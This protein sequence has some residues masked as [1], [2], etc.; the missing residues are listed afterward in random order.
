M[1]MHN[2]LKVQSASIVDL[3]LDLLNKHLM[4]PICLPLHRTTFSR[5][6]AEH[7]Q[8]DRSGTLTNDEWIELWLQTTIKCQWLLISVDAQCTLNSS[9][10]RFQSLQLQLPQQKMYCT[11]IGGRTVL[12][13]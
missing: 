4:I 9:Q 6:N 13:H 2:D 10:T 8:N 12:F 1:K 11:Y 5:H 7:R 3:E